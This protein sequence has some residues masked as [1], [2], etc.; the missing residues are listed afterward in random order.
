MT[1]F[2]LFSVNQL[3]SHAHVSRTNYATALDAQDRLQKLHD[4]NA[5]QA[6]H[7]SGRL[8]RILEKQNGANTGDQGMDEAMSAESIAVEGHTLLEDNPKEDSAGAAASTSFVPIQPRQGLLSTITSQMPPVPVAQ[9]STPDSQLGLTAPGA[10]PNPLHGT[11]Y[12]PLLPRHLVN[13]PQQ[14]LYGS[15]LNSIIPSIGKLLMSSLVPLQPNAPI[16]QDLSATQHAFPHYQPA[17]SSLPLKR[18]RGRPK[19]T[20]PK[21]FSA[22]PLLPYPPP[23][24]AAH[25]IQ[26]PVF[27]RPHPPPIMPLP[28]PESNPHFQALQSRD[29]AQSTSQSSAGSPAPHSTLLQHQEDSSDL[30]QKRGRPKKT[31]SS[32]GAIDPSL[33]NAPIAP[34]HQVLGP[35]ASSTI[36]P[37]SLPFSGDDIPRSSEGQEGSAH[38]QNPVL[39]K[40]VAPTSTLQSPHK[41]TSVEEGV[42]ATNSSQPNQNLEKDRAHLS[43]D[44]DA[45]TGSASPDPPTSA[46][47]DQ[48]LGQSDEVPQAQEVDILSLVQKKTPGRPRKSANNAQSTQPQIKSQPVK[49]GFAD[50]ASD[51]AQP[52]NS[53]SANQ[54]KRGR[55]RPNI[56]NPRTE[57][58]TPLPLRSSVKNLSDILLSSEDEGE[59]PDPLSFDALIRADAHSN[60]SPEKSLEENVDQPDPAPEHTP[61]ANLEHTPPTQNKPRGRPRKSGPINPNPA[62]P[63]LASSLPNEEDHLEILQITETRMIQAKETKQ[64]KLFLPDEEGPTGS[65]SEIEDDSLAPKKRRGR[66]KKSAYK[67]VPTWASQPEASADSAQIPESTEDNANL[68]SVK[69]SRGRPRMSALTP[70]ELDPSAE[71]LEPT[72]SLSADHRQASESADEG[73]S[74]PPAKK[75]RG[76]PRKSEPIVRMVPSWGARPEGLQ[77]PPPPVGSSPQIVRSPAPGTPLLMKRGPGRPRNVDSTIQAASSARKMQAPPDDDDMV[78]ISEGGTKFDLPTQSPKKT[79]GRPRRSGPMNGVAPSPLK[80]MSGTEGHDSVSPPQSPPQDDLPQ[81][82]KR[83]RGRPSKVAME[84]RASEAAKQELHLS[85][86]LSPKPQTHEAAQSTEPA[87]SSSIPQKRRRG[88]PSRVDLLAKEGENTTQAQDEDAVPTPVKRRPGRPRKSQGGNVSASGEDGEPQSCVV[89]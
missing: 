23:P 22:A 62:P 41:P 17:D 58:A 51:S 80:M 26:A 69:K 39:K 36:N 61:Q 6:A 77:N 33:S 10:P 32:I 57:V 18:K 70:E 85:S 60:F 7:P 8:G 3:S 20:D 38:Q 9:M 50:H 37:T 1:S 76:R 86:S 53:E 29:S 84:E 46:Q 45:P 13:P 42:H 43:P 48:E 28:L 63:I 81:E 30:K 31:D 52:N 5:F 66:P 25:P 21:N 89:Q 16:P 12:Q 75:P 87:L 83:K 71:V 14:L 34:N 11:P 4:P 56:L 27:M 24:L 49:P 88:R 74:L 65:Q 68:T 44:Q 59:T 2:G 73:T 72:R 78:E 54:Q 40:P 67:I 82:I 15:P 55:G 79:P 47:P 19:R 35:D 64:V